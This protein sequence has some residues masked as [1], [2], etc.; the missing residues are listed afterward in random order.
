[1]PS[2]KVQRTLSQALDTSHRL[3][4]AMESLP[5]IT[6]KLRYYTPPT[7][8]STP[9]VRQY[10]LPDDPIGKGLPTNV[11]PV[12]K[13]VQIHDLRA[14]DD[15]AAVTSVDTTGFQVVD[16][17][18]SGTTMKFE[19]WRSEEKIQSTY[20][21]EVKACVEV[22][23]ETDD[24]SGADPRMTLSSCTA[25]SRKSLDRPESKSLII[26]SGEESAKAKKR[27]MSLPTAS[28]SVSCKP[29]RAPA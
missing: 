10:L 26:R 7:D 25:F 18:I 28:P 2:A 22:D 20:Y 13:S 17:S 12:E 8:G 9:W 6:A 19:D 23:L 16:K 21:D 15:P 1:M 14:L 29:L 27:R 5:H 3:L 24:W 11:N 4:L